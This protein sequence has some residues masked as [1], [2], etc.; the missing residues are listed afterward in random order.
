V[1]AS[2]LPNRSR[3]PQGLTSFRHRNFRLFWLG[4]LV[5]LI[6]T[7]MQT[8]AQGWLLVELTH[9]DA[10]ALGLL[11][12]VQFMP[13]LVLG[14]FGGVLADAVPKRRA[15]IATQIVSGLLALILGL[16][17]LDKSVQVWHIFVLAGFLGVVN[18]FDMPLRQSF[19]VEMVGRDS[20]ANAVALNSAVFNATRIVGPAVA[21]ILIATLG[22]AACFLINAASYIAVIAG[23]LIMR[24]DELHRPPVSGLERSLRS[25]VAQ[26]AEGLRYVRDTPTIA[27]AVAIVA[28]VSTA[29]LNFVVLLPL[30]AQD[31]LGGG[32]TTYGFLSSAAGVGSLVGALSLAFGRAPSFR[33][34]LAGAAAIGLA[35]IGL[36]ISRWLPL[37]LVLMTVAGWGLIA[38]A[39]T[40]NMIIQLSTP[41][42][43]RGRV[44]S[45]YL[46]VFAGS[47]PIGG[48]ASG[49]IAATAGTPAAFIVAGVV[50]LLAVA[51]A[52]FFRWS[53]VTSGATFGSPASGDAAVSVKHEG[54]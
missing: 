4:Q 44:V 23:L 2:A 13:V 47:T 17:V 27:I 37:S 22:L 10:V 33:R 18:A 19:V 7:W 24:E 5:S 49:A 6:G 3:L 32:A 31:V 20:I 8:V 14:L 42:H 16:L 50:S 43:L 34:L 54:R 9:A 41:D 39:A 25:V 52:A 12:A 11:A 53:E 40:T 51:V 48:V 45:V 15:L 28:V 30:L 21:G 36:G 35:M 38:M 26:L 1:T 29:A 46:T